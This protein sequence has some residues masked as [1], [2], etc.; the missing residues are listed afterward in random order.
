MF[1][2]LRIET[3]LKNL[4][5]DLL[6]TDVD[7]NFILRQIFLKQQQQQQQLDSML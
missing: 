5:K 2:Q 1:D 3:E 4:D 6:K 7:K